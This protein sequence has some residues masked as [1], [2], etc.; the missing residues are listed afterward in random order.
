MLAKTL[1]VFYVWSPDIFVLIFIITLFQAL[2]ILLCQ[3]KHYHT[4]P[5]C[6]CA[7]VTVLLWLCYCGLANVAV[8][9]WLCCA[10]GRATGIY[11]WYSNNFF[12]NTEIHNELL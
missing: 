3:I 2:F 7:T 5:Y 6:G 8:L 12:D 4:I 11:L 1:V 10:T 9:L